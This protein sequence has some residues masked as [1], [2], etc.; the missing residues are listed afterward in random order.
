MI[1]QKVATLFIHQYKSSVICN[2]PLINKG[3]FFVAGVIR[4]IK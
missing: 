2:K 4:F 1:F 3:L